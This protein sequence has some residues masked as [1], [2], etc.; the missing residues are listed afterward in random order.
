M[1]S[2]MDSGGGPSTPLEMADLPGSLPTFLFD[3][4]ATDDGENIEP[5]LKS[6]LVARVSVQSHP[7]PSIA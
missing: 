1:S 6:E 7:I 5:F 2:R 3:W 4:E